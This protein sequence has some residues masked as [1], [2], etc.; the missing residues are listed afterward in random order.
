MSA[1]VSATR[2]NV[3]TDRAPSIVGGTYERVIAHVHFGVTQASA[4]TAIETLRPGMRAGNFAPC[5][6]GGSVGNQR[7]YSSFI[8][9]KSSSFA[10]TM[11]TLAILSIELPAA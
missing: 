11:V 6:A 10:R 9:A 4:I 7:T 2:S 8:P 1:I 3:R 5:R